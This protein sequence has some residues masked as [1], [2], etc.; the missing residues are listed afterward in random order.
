[1]AKAHSITRKIFTTSVTL[2]VGTVIVLA[3]VVVSL[4][5]IHI[6]PYNTTD[7]HIMDRFK[8]PS[9]SYFFGTDQY[10]RDLF[11]RVLVGGR[12]SLALGIGAVLLELILGIPIGIMTGYFGGKTDE[13]LMRLMDTLMSIPSLLMALL[14]L[15]ALG[16]SMLN[17][18]LAIGIVGAPRIAR[19]VRSATL[20]RKN[21][22]FVLAAKARGESNLYVMFGEIFP[23][24][25]SPTIIEASIGVGFAIMIGAGLSYL[26]LGVQP[27]N[28]D[29]GLMIRQAREYI[30]VSSYPMTVPGCALAF[31]I[32]GF[33]LLGD[34]LRD[35]IGEQT[36]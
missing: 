24:V 33:N 5:S 23:N 18:M 21:E 13:V 19:V 2:S 20:S 8:P 32:I 4:I 7:M 25:L 29:W 31:T 36:E 28:A 22:E 27:P 3:V 14:I 30:F 9:S 1:M 15:T 35:L 34:G 16:G 26:G 12:T 6:T 10:G 11:S 17:A